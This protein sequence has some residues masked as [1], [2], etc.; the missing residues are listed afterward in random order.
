MQRRRVSYKGVLLTWAQPLW[1]GCLGCVS[2]DHEPKGR[3]EGT[4]SSISSVP[5]MVKGLPHRALIIVSPLP[6][7]HV[8][9]PSGFSHDTHHA[10]AGSGILSLGSGWLHLLV[11]FYTE[12]VPVAVVAK[13]TSEAERMWGG[14]RGHLDHRKGLDASNDFRKPHFL[15]ILLCYW[16]KLVCGFFPSLL[17]VSTVYY[18]QLLSI[19]GHLLQWTLPNRKGVFMDYP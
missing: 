4:H 13:E 10:G 9:M 15:E 6:F 14:S 3:K 12:L 1:P 19:I 18:R 17:V 5:S 2:W 8:Q 7:V 11:R 16:W